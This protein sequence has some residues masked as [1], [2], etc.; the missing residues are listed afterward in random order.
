MD[1]W[2]AVTEPVIPAG[3]H[4]WTLGTVIVLAAETLA[5]ASLAHAIMN[6]RTSAGAWAWALGLLSFPFVAV[7]LYWVLGR[8]KFNGYR[9]SLREARERH[10]DL[11]EEISDA[12]EPHFSVLEG[13]AARFGCVLQK[14]SERRF[15]DGNRVELLVDGRHTFE[16]IF[17]AI[18]GA[19]DYL[20]VQFFILKEDGFGLE[21]RDRLIR[22]ARD[23]VRVFLLYDEIGSHRLSKRYLSGLLEAGVV[24]EAFQST[25]GRSNRFQI[26]F[27]NH[28]K[29][30]VA[31]GTVA[32]VGGHNVGDE[33]LGRD[34]RFGRWR[35]T[36][37]RLT[38]PAVQSTQLVFLGD[39][40]WA[41][42]E[43][44]RLNWK[45]AFIDP[46]G[47]MTVLPLATGPVDDLE[48]GTLFFLNSIHCA[49][50][51]LWIASPYFV[52]DE[53]VRAALQLAA[54]R[55]VDVR[56]MIPEKPDH[57]TVYLAG[58]SYLREME[59]AGVRMFRYRD[60]FLHQKVM[61]VDD[62]LASVGTANLDNR[63]L[64]LN[65]EVSLAVLDREFCRAVESMLVEDFENCREIDGRDYSEKP[66]PF[67]VAVR[68][69]RLAAPV[70]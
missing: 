26:N 46:E 14:L 38:G 34:P 35:D 44:P 48:A 18:D 45:P 57:R 32:F 30:V 59:A 6:A 39:W 10:E 28:R 7:P 36:H 54:L 9:Q 64:R 5:V 40:Y 65:F 4:K 66:L 69:A 56:I 31:D 37:V 70:L 12:L 51:R 52:P 55:G 50:E 19:K 60:G 23:G 25:R 8:K 21:F 11:V 27:R 61:L 17:R 3:V 16:E 29:I 68:L 47:G 42:R 41:R 53:S 63:S 13:E 33:Y 67:R 62:R 2:V 1:A 20:L 24:V 49:R 58:F 22:K 15:T 43:A